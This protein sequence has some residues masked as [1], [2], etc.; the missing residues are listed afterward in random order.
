MTKAAFHWTEVQDAMCT[1]ILV[2]ST[3]IILYL[4]RTIYNPYLYYIL[5]I[6]Y[7][8]ILYIIFYDLI[9]YDIIWNDM[10]WYYIVLY[11]QT[12]LYNTHIY[13]RPG[14]Q[15]NADLL[16]T[17]AKRLLIWRLIENMVGKPRHRQVSRTRANLCIYRNI[18]Y[19]YV[20]ICIYVY[21]QI[22][23]YVYVYIYI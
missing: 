8:I 18:M 19:I 5:Y 10:I 17:E 13:T 3:Y 2:N 23:I 6:L 14:T 15:G 21:M 9:W 4:Y 1:T 7:Y 12:R 11:Y 20:N 16:H 22:C